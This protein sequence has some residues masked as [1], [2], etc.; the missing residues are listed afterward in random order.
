M[1]MNTEIEIWWKPAQTDFHATKKNLQIE[2]YYVSVF[3]SEQAAEK[4]LKYGILK[5]KKKLVKVHDLVF[6]GKILSIPEEVNE[7][8]IDLNKAYIET[9]YPNASGRIPSE[10]FTE[11]HAKK[12][13]K[14]A[15]DILI[16]VEKNT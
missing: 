7:K 14:L 8:C 1:I 13:L 2:E 4:A 16:W 9:R 11:E 12:F 10:K 3:L 6:L 15:E 5:Q